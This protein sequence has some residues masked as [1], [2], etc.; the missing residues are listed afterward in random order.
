MKGT[1]IGNERAT[2]GND[3]LSLSLSVCAAASAAVT[4]ARL[5]GG[6]L[7][8]CASDRGG[9]C[10]CAYVIGNI[11]ERAF[12]VSGRDDNSERADDGSAFAVCDSERGLIVVRIAVVSVAGAVTNENSVA[13]GTEC[14]GVSAGDAASLTDEEAAALMTSLA[15]EFVSEVIAIAC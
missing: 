2:A 5:I 14:T 13:D 11:A 10:V 6:R 15:V 1:A 12:G 7:G 9:D 3:G 8:G 4:P